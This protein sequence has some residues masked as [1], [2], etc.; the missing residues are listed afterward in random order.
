MMEDA[1]QKLKSVRERLGLTFRE[2]EEHSRR[3]AEV[4]GSDEFIIAI[5]R[6]AD[7]ESNRTPSLYR[8]YSICAIYRLDFAEVLSWYGVS[9]ANQAADAAM[10]NLAKTH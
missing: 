1:G 2:V 8:L 3:I 4:H 5:S 9:L 6:L 7:I 10:L